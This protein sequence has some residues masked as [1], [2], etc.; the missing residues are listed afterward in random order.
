MAKTD[1]QG[2]IIIPG[3]IL[4]VYDSENDY[5]TGTVFQGKGKSLTIV[6]DPGS[7]LG[8]KHN[9][10]D[11]ENHN[12]SYILVNR[13]EPVKVKE[14]Q[15]FTQEDL[16]NWNYLISRGFTGQLKR[17]TNNHQIIITINEL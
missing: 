10:R 13:K 16:D 3:D 7:K 15:L 9:L 17:I 1:V 12:I 8:G 2:H 11:L 6:M 5:G 4:H 14:N